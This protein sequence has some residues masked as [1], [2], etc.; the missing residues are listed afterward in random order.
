MFLSNVR[1]TSSTGVFDFVVHHCE[2]MSTR[3]ATTADS[4]LQEQEG[5]AKVL[6]D[7]LGPLLSAP[8]FGATLTEYFELEDDLAQVSEVL[9]NPPRSASDQAIHCIMRAKWRAQMAYVH[10]RSLHGAY[11]NHPVQRA[12]ELHVVAHKLS[13]KQD[14]SRDLSADSDY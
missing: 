3:D 7:E 1:G 9:L 10:E 8:S 14:K 4:G 11:L 12:F 13:I 5:F 2:R 6:E